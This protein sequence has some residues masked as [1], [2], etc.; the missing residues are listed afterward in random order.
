[1]EESTGPL[2][3]K[4]GVRQW[5]GNN[6]VYVFFT[7]EDTDYTIGSLSL[8]DLNLATRGL[9]SEVCRTDNLESLPGVKRQG[10]KGVETLRGFRRT[11]GSPGV[12]AGETKVRFGTG[13]KVDLI[14]L[15]SLSP[16]TADS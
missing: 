6:I 11:H 1:M 14:Y 2:L 12:G 3:T 8:R 9:G 15:L 10:P 13:P 5:K 7:E 16:L 4:D